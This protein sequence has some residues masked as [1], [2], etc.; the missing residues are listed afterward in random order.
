MAAAADPGQPDPAVAVT[1]S[2]RSSRTP[3]KP[4]LA[5]PGQRPAVLARP[6]PGARP[7]PVPHRPA[8]VAPIMVL[9]IAAQDIGQLT[10]IEPR[11]RALI[12]CWTATMSRP[13]CPSWTVSWNRVRQTSSSG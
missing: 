12:A 2:S 13:A 9:Q 6:L 7:G 10:D 1:V 8:P 3:G 11:V 5:D 4:E